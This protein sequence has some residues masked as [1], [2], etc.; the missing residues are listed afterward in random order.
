MPE[1]IKEAL[2]RD[3]E[4]LRVQ[5]AARARP[6]FGILV[7]SLIGV[8]VLWRSSLFPVVCVPAIVGVVGYAY[9]R[10]MAYYCRTQVEFLKRDDVV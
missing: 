4:A 8:V 3:F 2:I 9:F 1:S 6:F 10:L 7:V 5:W